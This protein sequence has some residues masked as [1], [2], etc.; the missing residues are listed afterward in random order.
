MIVVD[1]HQHFWNPVRVDY[2]WLEVD[3]PE[4]NRPYVFADLE[5]HLASCGVQATVLVQSGESLEDNEVMFEIARS[6]SRVAGIVAWVPIEDAERTDALLETFGR[7]H[8][9]VGVRTL[10]QNQPDPDWLLRSDVARGLD[11]VATRGLPF[12]FL[13]KFARHLRHVPTLCERHPEL[14]IV[15]DHLA[16]PP[17]GED[18][19]AWSDLLARAAEAPNV[20]A[21]V[22]GL[23]PA[24]GDRAPWTLEDIRPA[25]ARALELFGSSRLM[26]GSDWPV[27]ELAGG[28]ET[29]VGALFRL[30]EELSAEERRDLLGETAV[31]FYGLALER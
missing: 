5:P 20:F 27:C 19:V 28:Y 29:V 6:E 16:K 8:R 17:I 7:A 22:S 1:A 12:D 21:K 13:G 14:R 24:A 11:V 9:V 10:A 2:P 18:L 15:I 30:F 31:R 25:L 3:Y 26:F 4:L 23:Y